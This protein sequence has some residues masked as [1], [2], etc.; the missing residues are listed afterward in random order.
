MT[1]GPVDPEILRGSGGTGRHPASKARSTGVSAGPSGSAR[2]TTVLL[3]LD[4]VLMDHRTAMREAVHAWLGERATLDVVDA[5]FRSMEVHL[6]E[7]RAG[8][9]TWAEQRRRRLRDVLP[10]LGEP[11]GAD[12]ELDARFATGYLPAYE[13]A[14]R[15]YDDVVPALAG[16]RAADYRLGVLTNGS[17]RQQRAKLRALELTDLVGPVFTAEAVGAP[18]PDPRAFLAACAGLAVSPDEVLYVGDEHETDVLGARGAGLSA[19]LLDR[20]GTAPA[21]ETAVIRSLAELP[22]LLSR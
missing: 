5:W 19:V 3:D 21:E 15:G 22:L 6:A 2:I 14:W 13:R 12:A 8:T 4:G 9:A 7:W 16:L 20:F 17:E 11:V 1:P 10:L 18:K